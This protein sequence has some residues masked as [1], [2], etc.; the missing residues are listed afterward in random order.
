MK[1]LLLLFALFIAIPSFAQIEEEI[2]NYQPKAELIMKARGLMVEKLKE[3]DFAKVKEIK[4][5][6]LSLKDEVST[7][8]SR[9]ELW[10]I[11][12]LTNE[13]ETLGN[14]IA[15]MNQDNY[16]YSKSTHSVDGLL[17]VLRETIKANKT[18]L[19]SQ[20][21]QAALD[22]ETF[23]VIRMAL[24]WQLAGEIVNRD[25]YNKATAHLA[26]YPKTRYEFFVRKMLFERFHEI[27]YGSNHPISQG[28][29]R[30]NSWSM[31]FVAS[32]GGC[33]LIGD[34]SELYK[35]YVSLGFDIVVTYRRFS[36]DGGICFMPMSTGSDIEG[37]NG[38]MEKGHD[39]TA[40]MPRGDFGFN[41][42]KK[43]NF[44]MKPFLGVGGM[45]I[46]HQNLPNETDFSDLN[47]NAL[48]FYGG[49]GFDFKLKSEINGYDLINVKY[50][51]GVTP[52]SGTNKVSGMHV[53]SV[54][55][56]VEALFR[57]NYY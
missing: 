3:K 30:Q 31:G 16:Y 40:L 2:A 23:N 43:E 12:F 21:K 53:I 29:A 13:F 6:A 15:A 20:M 57:R 35:S 56:S 32:L 37:S 7:P 36:F 49:C 46:R 47:F 51:F 22:E 8:F 25:I 27:D 11:L 34:L 1:R 52:F 9:T 39:V 14:E 42:V 24:D 19:R 38:V 17:M 50:M 41:V 4:D 55:Y 28:Y 5:Y 44:R 48:T 26:I 45:L 10:S 54:G 33:C 18:D